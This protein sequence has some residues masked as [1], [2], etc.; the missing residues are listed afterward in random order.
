MLLQRCMFPV[1][2]VC[3]VCKFALPATSG[4]HGVRLSE[5]RHRRDG[6]VVLGIDRPIEE[7]KKL[8]KTL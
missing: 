1:S 4:C 8:I 6:L 2:W 5:G 7:K 3:V